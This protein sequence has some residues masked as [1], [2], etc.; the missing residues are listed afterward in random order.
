MTLIKKS[1]VVS[2]KLATALFLSEF[3]N[4]ED[5]TGDF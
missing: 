5:S 2:Q 1:A 4:V 3:K